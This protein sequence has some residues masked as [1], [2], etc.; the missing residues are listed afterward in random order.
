MSAY[1]CIFL[2]CDCIFLHISSDPFLLALYL[3]IPVSFQQALHHVYNRFALIFIALKLPLQ[4]DSLRG[5]ARWRQQPQ[6]TRGLWQLERQICRSLLQ[7]A[8]SAA[9]AAAPA[10]AVADGGCWPP[11]LA[12]S[13]YCCGNQQQQQRTQRS[14]ATAER[15]KQAAKESQTMETCCQLQCSEGSRPGSTS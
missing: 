5:S 7:T 4:M 1:N 2:A 9:A 12:T 14:A 10:A 13:H 3:A 11:L 6:A 15:A 8:A